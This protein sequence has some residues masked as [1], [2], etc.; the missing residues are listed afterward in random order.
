[1]SLTFFGSS[2]FKQGIFQC[3]CCSKEMPGRGEQ[4]DLRRISYAFATRVACQIGDVE[5]LYRSLR[6]AAHQLR[7]DAWRHLTQKMRGS[8]GQQAFAHVSNLATSIA[9]DHAAQARERVQ[10]RMQ[11]ENNLSGRLGGVHGS[12]GHNLQAG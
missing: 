6:V 8:R 7:V 4:V 3:G 11:E 2:I 1:M 5:H 10:G 12:N 9:V